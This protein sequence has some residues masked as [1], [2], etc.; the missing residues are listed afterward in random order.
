MKQAMR[1]HPRVFPR[2][3]PRPR[4]CLEVLE[5]R[6]L[7][8]GGAIAARRLPAPTADAA[9]VSAG[10]DSRGA[11]FPED[12]TSAALGPAH[13]PSDVEDLAPG[14]VAGANVSQ[15]AIGT[16]LPGGPVLLARGGPEL[17]VIPASVA[18]DTPVSVSAVPTGR[19][20]PPAVPG[21]ADDVR[22]PGSASPQAGT[23]GPS[24]PGFPR[25][26]GVPR[27]KP[28]VDGPRAANVAGVAGPAAVRTEPMVPVRGFGLAT[29]A[30]PFARES[31]AR[32]FDRFFRRFEAPGGG[33]AGRRESSS[34]LVPSLVAM[35]VAAVAVEV[36]ALRLR[37]RRAGARPDTSPECPAG[38]IGRHG[39]P[40][41]PSSP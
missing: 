32:A 34:P 8:S 10:G 30:L 12:E 37:R 38:R 16:A 7:L 5:E 4:L 27:A 17:G 25:S 33:L 41:L 14:R 6:F 18:G 39:L 3:R 35:L 9:D 31:L 2:P 26:P 11:D 40:G 24:G 13:A 28:F 21:V 36:E 22:P 29:E 20:I 19:P 1:M 23:F 15:P